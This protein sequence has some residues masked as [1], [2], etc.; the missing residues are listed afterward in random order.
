MICIWRRNFLRSSPFSAEDVLAVERRRSRGRRDQADERPAEGRLAAAG[1]ADE[2]EDLAALDLEADV[3][4]GLHVA[5]LAAEDAAVDR[6]VLDEVLDVDERLLCLGRRCGRRRQFRVR[7]GIDHDRFASSGGTTGRWRGGGGS[8]GARRVE[9]ARDV[10]RVRVVDP[11]VMD[12]ARLE[13]V[14]AARR[15]VAARRQVERVGRPCP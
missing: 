4:D 10:R 8:P 6:V 13:G 2:P 7:S 1:L 14:R 11:R 12:R 5:D 9:P 15:E 3:V